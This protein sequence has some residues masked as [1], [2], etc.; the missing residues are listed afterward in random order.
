MSFAPYMA[1]SARS[2]GKSDSRQIFREPK[3]TNK[4]LERSKE[5]LQQRKSQQE[6]MGIFYHYR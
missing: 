4:Y 3:G 1:S 6:K 2:L 5:A